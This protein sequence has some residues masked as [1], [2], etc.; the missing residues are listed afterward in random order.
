MRVNRPLGK[1]SGHP[2]FPLNQLPQSSPS[3]AEV[4]L[5]AFSHVCS[6][7]TL[8]RH[9]PIHG[10]V[11][12]GIRLGL[13][14]LPPPSVSPRGQIRSVVSSHLVCFRLHLPCPPTSTR[15]KLISLMRKEYSRMP[16]VGIRTRRMSS[17]KNGI[18]SCHH[19]EKRNS[20]SLNYSVLCTGSLV[21]FAWI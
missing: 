16:V 5:G 7:L 8:Q 2:V 18:T 19:L 21:R 17:C 9:N 1:P 6:L 11:C 10:H 3:K 12:F 13:L 4:N 15:R 20:D 14:H